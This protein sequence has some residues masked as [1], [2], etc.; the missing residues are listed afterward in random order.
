MY[1]NEATL[2]GF[3]RPPASL[4]RM[5]EFEG[6][7]IQYVETVIVTGQNRSLHIPILITGEAMKAAREWFEVRPEGFHAR[8]QSTV[9][10]LDDTPRLVVNFIQARED[11]RW[12]MFE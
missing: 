4:P 5:L 11:K 10:M 1:T 9:M 7:K 12:Q 8:T 2:I 6:N 3:I